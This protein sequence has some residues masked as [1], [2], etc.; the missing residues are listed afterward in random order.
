MSL[1]SIVAKFLAMSVSEKAAFAFV[2][3]SSINQAVKSFQQGNLDG[4]VDATYQYLP[5]K[6]SEKASADEI[7]AAIRSY[8]DAYNKTEALFKK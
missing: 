4:L 6:Y 1:N 7:K 3:F 2:M 8:I 5:A